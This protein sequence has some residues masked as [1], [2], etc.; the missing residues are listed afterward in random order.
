MRRPYRSRITPIILLAAATAC[1]SSPTDA[2][3]DAVPIGG[4][5]AATVLDATTGGTPGF[6]FLP[7]TVPTTPAYSGT[8]DGSLLPE[9]SVEVCE[10]DAAGACPAAP[11]VTY[12]ATGNARHAIRLN[13]GRDLYFVYWNVVPP[14]AAGAAF[15]ATV[16]A[17]GRDLGHVD[18]IEPVAGRWMPIAFRIEEGALD[19]VDPPTEPPAEPPP[20]LITSNADGTRVGSGLQHGTWTFTLETPAPPGG[21]DV[22]IRSSDPS[23]LLVAPDAATPGADRITVSLGGGV[24]TGTFW[25][26]GMEGV[27]GTSV[28]EFS[29]AGFAGSASIDVVPVAASI[30]GLGASVSTV[31]P[32]VP[33][34]VR[35]GALDDAGTGMHALQAVRAGGVPLTFTITNSNATVARLVTSGGADQ[36]RTV[37]I[38]AGEWSSPAT[39]AAGGVAFDAL[40]GGTTTVTAAHPGITMLAGA[41]IDVT[42][43]AGLNVTSGVRVG[44][45][46]MHLVVFTLDAP[47]PAGG[48]TVHLE[49]SDPGLL[50]LAP[51]RTTVGTASIDVTIGGGSGG[52][53]FLI[54]GVEGVTGTA[55]ITAT[56]PGYDTGVGTVTVTPVGV[57]L[58]FLATSQTATGSNDPFRV[59]VGGINPS[60]TGLYTEQDVR[61]GGTPIVVDITNSDAAIAQLITS[62][63]AAQVVTVTIPVGDSRSP[64]DLAGGGVEFDP[65]TPGQTTVSVYGAGLI[66]VPGATQT[67]T[68]N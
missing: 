13:P 65:L 59:A 20:A 34:Q 23:L 31:G 48:L 55:T 46:L 58:L 64:L 11:I 26:Q 56:A 45:G 17:S 67:I 52:T 50:L 18:F 25:V 33:F 24:L 36:V 63:G 7:P 68:I 62:A 10:L 32:D 5:H 38:A 43:T 14:D 66:Q 4:T 16:I 40:A 54:A 53:G 19:E 42:V 30:L 12:S 27:T 47:A 51:N 57:R 9:L 3:F 2:P 8:F 21:I 41:T 37:D 6:Y 35:V 28:V 15:R 49:S 39:V 29:A 22:E 61:F 1:D 60:G 44:A